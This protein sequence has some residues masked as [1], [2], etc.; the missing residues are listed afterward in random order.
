MTLIPAWRK[1]YKMFSVQA[2]ALIGALQVA[3]ASA[4]NGLMALHVPK[5]TGVTWADLLGWLTFA[6]ALLGAI[7]RL[8]DQGVSEAPQ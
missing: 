7:G 4:P 3:A 8:V 2:L 1:A 6:A 5:L